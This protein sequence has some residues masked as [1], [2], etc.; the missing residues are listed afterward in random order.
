MLK[1]NLKEILAKNNIR[2]SDLVEITG[3]TKAT[4]SNI[5]NNKFEPSIG[6]A[7]KIAKFLNIP[8]EEIFYED[9]NIIDILETPTMDK[10]VYKISGILLVNNK[11]TEQF[12]IDRLK[13]SR[14]ISFVNIK[15]EK[16]E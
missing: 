13:N 4:I 15:L 7:F 10:V 12:I 11:L 1:N 5:V 14:I 9:D 6:V 2:Q 8:I 16:L 3:V